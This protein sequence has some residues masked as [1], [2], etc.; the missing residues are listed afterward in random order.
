MKVNKTIMIVLA[1]ILAM[2]IIPIPGLVLDILMALN[3]LSALVILL[4]IINTKKAT[5]FSSFPTI[6]LLST[7][8]GLVVNLTATR[9]ILTKGMNFDG[10]LIQAFAFF[11]SSFGKTGLVMDLVIDFVVFIVF[12]AVHLTVI[13]K[14]SVRLTEVA[15][16]FNLDA[17]P[18]KQMAIE[19]EYNSGEINEE[20]NVS[21]KNELQREVD[22]FGAMD[23]VSKFISGNEKVRILII[24]TSIVGGILIGTVFRDESIIVSIKT[25]FPLI[26]SNGI[27]CII[28]SFLLSSTAGIII[29]HTLGDSGG[30]E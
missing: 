4:I 25:Y 13:V 19:A 20:E 17:L 3:L 10:R 26:I 27:L 1:V 11:V 28:P 29:T 21:K 18:G 2:L 12:I 16:R 15:A 14:G 9:L 8:F 5:D 7:F 23:G 30:D 22:F 6:L 24:L